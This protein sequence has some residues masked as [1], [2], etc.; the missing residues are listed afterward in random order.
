VVKV[1]VAE[2]EDL[3]RIDAEI[4]DWFFDLADVRLDDARSEL[5]V[6]F[7]RWS[8][9][10][11][12]IVRGAAAASYKA[13]L[14]W[15]GRKLT[16]GTRWEAPWYRWVLRIGDALRYEMVDEARIG[17][18]DFYGVRYHADRSVVDIAC[19]IPV[20][21]S[22]TVGRLLVSVEQTDEFIGLARYTT[23]P[24]G[25]DSYG[26]DVLPVD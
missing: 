14:A 24:G 26:G 19:N 15:L 25:A 7:R 18:A 6:P 11:A 8:Y 4:H 13:R 22:I 2:A 23:W 21:I 5:V 3:A 1:V 16:R 9:R 20:T 10:E 17:T 12:R